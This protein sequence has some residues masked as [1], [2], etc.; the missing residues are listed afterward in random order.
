MMM[1][2]VAFTFDD[3]FPRCRIDRFCRLLIRIEVRFDSEKPV[4]VVIVVAIIIGRHCLLDCD[5]S[6]RFVFGFLRRG[7]A[8][9]GGVGI[10]VDLDW[11]LLPSLLYAISS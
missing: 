2:T 8:G 11:D 1:T 10:V 9:G 6:K 3:G 7:R 5:E 4:I